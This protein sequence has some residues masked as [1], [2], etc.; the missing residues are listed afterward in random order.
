MTRHWRPGIMT[1]LVV[2]VA[3]LAMV[4]TA[5]SSDD[6]DDAS[7]I[8]QADL[9]AVTAE[10]ADAND[11]ISALEGQLSSAQVTTQ[12]VQAGEL[13]AAPAAGE[14][15]DDGWTN[16]ESIR[17]GLFLE[18]EFDSSGPDAWD[19]AAHPRVYF[20]SESFQ[21]NYYSDN[22]L[23]EELGNFAGWHVVDAYSK[24][25][26]ASALYQDIVPGEVNRGPHGVG[27]SPDGKWGYVGF[28]VSPAEG[29]ESEFGACDRIGYVAIVNIQTMK[30]DKVLRQ[31]SYFEGGFRSQAIHHIQCWTQDSTGNDYCIL[32]WGFGANGGPHHIISPSDNNRVYRSITYDDVK[33][34]G[35]PFTTPSPDGDYVYISMGANFLRESDLP[36]A[37]IAKFEID[38]GKHEEFHEVGRH[39]I[40]ITHTQDGKYTYVI[41]GTSSQI[42]KLDNETTHVVDRAAAGIAGPYG[43]CL[44][45]DETEAWINGKGEGTANLGNS[46]SIFDL[47]ERFRASRAHGNTPF[48]LGGSASS[49]DHCALHPDPEV[50]E[51][52]ISNMKGWET[53]VVDLD[54]YT[55]EAYIN[56]PNNGD[57]HG[58][59]FVYYDGGWDDGRLM[60]DMGGPKDQ[61]LQDMIRANA[62][63]AAAG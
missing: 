17:G 11:Q 38:T 30:V 4:A 29:C 46:M 58:M 43:I 59:A 41:D 12:V 55:V 3:V 60:V 8:S 49:V 61:A 39:P 42:Y 51:I 21:S 34:M 14:I 5:C 31:E 15:P 2:L 10:L 35:H 47:G 54:T 16:A 52:W 62:E 48:Y 40:G 24:E 19:I 25:V 7:G 1:R 28:A 26:V 6:E 53:I 37:G 18:A 50:N 32:Q 23:S 27:V 63:A 57:T 33:P 56:T 22:E 9:D 44:N 20:T 13:A 45:W 36:G